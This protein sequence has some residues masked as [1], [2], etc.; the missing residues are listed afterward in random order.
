[1]VATV[2]G[3]WTDE[4][5][6]SHK[7]RYERNKG[8]C[9]ERSKDATNGAPGLT[10]RSKDAILVTKGIAASGF[11]GLPLRFVQVAFL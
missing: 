1:M 2:S 6:L 11:F 8:H 4:G 7:G 3:F 9:Y 10:T 5:P